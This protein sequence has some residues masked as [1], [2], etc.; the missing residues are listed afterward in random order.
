MEEKVLRIL[1]NNLSKQH[2]KQQQTGLQWLIGV[3]FMPFTVISSLE[4]LHTDGDPF[5]PNY[6][7]EAGQ[8]YYFL[9]HIQSPFKNCIHCIWS[10]D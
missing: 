7:A 4:C 1:C 2:G 5:T 6:A 3:P 9:T 10:L 8:Y